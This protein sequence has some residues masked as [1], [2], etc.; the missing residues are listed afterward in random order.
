MQNV[1]RYQNLL[2]I[3]LILTILGLIISPKIAVSDWKGEEIF[4]QSFLRDFYSENKNLFSIGKSLP[5]GSESKQ[6]TVFYSLIMQALNVF[7]K[8]VY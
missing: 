6:L 1:I 5:S 4:F 7:L 2:K 3:K 8:T